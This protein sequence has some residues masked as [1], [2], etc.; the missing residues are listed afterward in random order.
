MQDK[1]VVITG[2]AQGFG[3]GV[4]MIL[5]DEGAKIVIADLNA[6]KGGKVTADINGRHGKGR[7]IFVRTDVSDENSVRGL[8]DETVRQFGRIDTLI[9]NAGILRVG[10]LDSISAE[11]LDAVAAVN[12]RG[13]FLCAKYASKIM[14]KQTAA[15]PD[16]YADIIQINSKSGLCG[17]KANFAYSGSKFG[18]IGLTQSFALEL[19]PYRIKVNSICPGN[20]LDGPLW[21]DPENGLLT[22]YLNAGKVPGAKTVD[23]VKE[24]YLSKVPMHKG[25]TPLDIARAVMY[26]VEQTGETGQAIPVTGG[27]VMLG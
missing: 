25:C 20:F 14:K 27:Q 19:A 10:D 16:Y 2:A 5:S 17:S 13:Y 22:Q 26:A 1:V 8:M 9:S 24:Y 7:A 21:S 11:D 3:E 23:Q 4:A 6:E 18:A 15:E 12:Y